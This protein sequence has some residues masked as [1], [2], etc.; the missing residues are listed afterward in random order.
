MYQYILNVHLRN[1][2]SKV[3]YLQ[4][5]GSPVLKVLSFKSLNWISE[6]K[7]AE[8]VQFG[9]LG[10]IQN[11]GGPYIQGNHIKHTFLN[12][13]RHLVFINLLF[14]LLINLQ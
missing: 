2:W 12:T 1:D 14:T 10:K 3:T 7:L 13:F 5:H 8:L 4:V 9:R 11:L 6:T